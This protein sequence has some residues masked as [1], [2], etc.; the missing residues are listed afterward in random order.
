[1][2][3][4]VWPTRSPLLN[5]ARRTGSGPVIVLLHGIASSSVTFQNLEPLLSDDHECIMIDLLGFGESP[6]PPD[7]DYTLEEHVAA[8]ERT[9]KHL[10]I[11]EPFILVGHSMGALIA[12]RFA[13]RNNKV[14][15]HLVLVSPP[16][17]VSPIELSD[18]L[19]RGVVD[20]YLRAY[21]YLRT[22]KDF[23][24][25]HA[26]VIERLLP[27]PKVMDINERTWT[28]FVKS[29]EHAIESQTTLS[30]LAAV[31]APVEIVYGSLDQFHSDGVLKIV[32]RM[33]GVTVT[34]VEASDHII[35]KRLARA[36]ARTIR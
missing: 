34:R 9:V 12:A 14:V 20:F 35:G 28:P 31:D 30:D 32:S 26:A 8:I 36:V 4:R 23:T 13:A 5:V 25:R 15:K 22:N 27:I 17:Y 16:I 24:L 7:A 19:D 10:R 6:M 1:M 33:S 18:R 3:P 2:T 21:R 29:L 11:R